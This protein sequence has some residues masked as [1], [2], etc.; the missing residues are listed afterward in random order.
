MLDW[1]KEFH[2]G[3]ASGLLEVLACNKFKMFVVAL[4]F[5]GV[6]VLVFNSVEACFKE[7]FYH[8]QSSL[9]MQLRTGHIGL[10]HHLFRIKHSETP[11]CPHCRGLTVETVKHFLLDCPFYCKGCHMLQLKLRRN[12]KS[13]SF[14]LSNLLLLYRFWNLFTPQADSNLSLAPTTSLSQMHEETQK[15]VPQLKRCLAN[16]R[17]LQVSP[18]DSAPL[19]PPTSFSPP[20]M[21]PVWSPFFFFPTPP[22]FRSHC[23]SYL[24]LSHIF[25]FSG[26]RRGVLM[27]PIAC[28]S[29]IFAFLHR[30]R[31]ITWSRHTPHMS[32]DLSRSLPIISDHFQP[33]PMI[34]TFG[35]HLALVAVPNSAL[36]STPAVR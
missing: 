11:V 5:R 20:W 33:F 24:L 36:R 13:L 21:G 14:L 10:N 26:F 19:L 1:G 12:A 31:M 17:L 29:C 35:R 7:C 4:L 32:H 6:K 22:F 9:L 8:R 28:Y 34:F 16:C 23:L 30:L 18:N 2:N 25:K 27:S 3:I 15:S